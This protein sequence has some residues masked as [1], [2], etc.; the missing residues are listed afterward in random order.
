[1]KAI[2][3][4]KATPKTAIIAKRVNCV[5][6]FNPIS[7]FFPT[8]TTNIASITKTIQGHAIL[9]AGIFSKFFH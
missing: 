1:M 9:H 6:E 3:T 2:D 5:T 4:I 8:N 7:S